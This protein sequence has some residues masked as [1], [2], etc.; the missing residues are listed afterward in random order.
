MAG[1]KYTLP[2]HTLLAKNG[3]RTGAFFI[4]LAVALGITMLFVF[5]LFRPVFKK[6]KTADLDLIK[7]EELNSGLYFANEKGEPTNFSA[8]SD[9]TV[10]IDSM[11]YFYFSYLPGENIKEGLEPSKEKREYTIDWFNENI[12]DINEDIQY[13]VFE[14]K[15][16]G[17]IGVVK[18]GADPILVNKVVQAGYV[19]SISD[20]FNDLANVKKA[21]I[22][23]ETLS[24]ISYVASMFIAGSITYILIPWLLKDGQTVGKKVF[25]LGLA[26]SNGYKFRN[27][28]LLM[29]FMPAAVMIV[30]L[31]L[32]MYVDIFL[33]LSIVGIV[34]LVSFAVAMSSPK[35]MALHDFTAQSIVVDLKNSKLFETMVEE[36]AYVLKEDN[37]FEDIQPS[38]GEEPE[39]K[40][41]K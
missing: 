37:L 40:Y 38:E 26:T 23:Y 24:A 3:A 31:F 21:N 32:L 22:H 19:W 6:S 17:E 28:Q 34:F 12:L 39:L 35:H 5:A 4:D 15:N 16:P 33:D 29:R 9:Y 7:H 14:V 20:I 2:R 10:F 30:A 13:K 18:E 1:K 25:G 27:K 8:D 11:K 36:E 41:E